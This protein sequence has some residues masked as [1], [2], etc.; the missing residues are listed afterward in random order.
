MNFFHRAIA[1]SLFLHLC[2]LL[3]DTKVGKN[4]SSHGKIIGINTNF[5]KSGNMLK[6]GT[7]DYI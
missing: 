7:S 2:T 6:L 4:S 1:S 3:E 5:L